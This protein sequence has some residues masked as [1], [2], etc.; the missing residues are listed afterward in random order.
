MKQF[1][2]MIAML[3]ATTV[4]VDA[5]ARI[6]SSSLLSHVR[7]L[8]SDE[9]EGRLA[10]SAGG[11][12]TQAY[13]VAAFEKIGLQPCGDAFRH[14]FP[15]RGGRSDRRGSNIL[16]LINGTADAADVIVLSAHFDHLGS[17]RGDIYNGADDN[18][19]GVAALIEIARL[20]VQNPPEHSLLIAAFDAEEAGLMGSRAFMSNSCV[21]EGRIVI[22]VNMDM[23]SRSSAGEL[24]ASGTYHYPALA[25]ILG[26]VDVPSR[27]GL[28]LGHDLPG[29]G[30]DDWTLASDHGPFYERGIPYLYFGVEDHAGYHTTQDDFDQI[31]VPFYVD[32]VE[33]IVDVL[34]ALD[35]RMDVVR[36]LRHP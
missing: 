5:Q 36:T 26:E 32:S 19:S 1:S 4:R 23:I 35:R 7:V 16:G 22:N 33:L 31:T 28:I 15:L 34:E 2:L 13:L 25:Q 12:K 6:D 18:A 14:D 29:T 24:Y 17:D 27:T 21:D 11:Q 8:S 10:G 9:F 30:M 20:F 3:I